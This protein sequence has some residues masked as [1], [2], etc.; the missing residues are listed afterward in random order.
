[1]KFYRRT[2]LKLLAAIPAI[3]IGSARSEVQYSDTRQGPTI[4]IAAPQNIEELIIWFE[5]TFRCAIGFP[6]SH[7]QMMTPRGYPTPEQDAVPYIEYAM[8]TEDTERGRKALAQSFWRTF[9][10]KSL[11]FPDI[12]GTPLYWR[13][14][15]KIESAAW[16]AWDDEWPYKKGDRLIR[17]YTRLAIPALQNS[18]KKRLAGLPVFDSSIL[19]LETMVSPGA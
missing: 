3:A 19:S 14:E 15:W 1:M 13:N 11:M 7:S 12:I 16:S 18:E 6:G 4:T 2:F 10:S 5:N 9:L 8:K 17:I